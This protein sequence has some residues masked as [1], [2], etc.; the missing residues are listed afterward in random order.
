MPDTNG[1]PRN[2]VW[3]TMGGTENFFQAHVFDENGN[4]ERTLVQGPVYDN[5]LTPD[6]KR[7]DTFE[8]RISKNH[9]WFGMPDYGQAWV[10]GPVALDWSVGV[11]Q[12]GHH[13][14]NPTKDD[15]FPNAACRD[16][17]LGQCRDLTGA[18]V[19]DGEVRPAM[20]R[21]GGPDTL[22][23]LSPAPADAYLRFL[24]IGGNLEFRV[25]GGSWQAPH[26]QFG[27][28]NIDPSQV[29]ESYLTPIPAGARSIQ[30]RGQGTYGGKW[31]VQ[32]VA[33]WT[34]LGLHTAPTTGVV[35]PAA[36]GRIWDSRPGLGTI[37]GVGSG[38]GAFAAGSTY[39]LPVAGRAGVAVGAQ[40]AV[41]NLT[42]AGDRY[43]ICHCLAVRT[44]P[45]ER[46]EPE[47]HDR[48]A[49]RERCLHE[50]RRGRPCVP[51]RRRRH[52]SSHRRRQRHIRERSCSPPSVPHV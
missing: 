41:I 33:V 34:E 26:R 2:A 12:F 15:N 36:I 52:H 8:L 20:G 11:V 22:Q 3:I 25:D 48:C 47:L 40:S 24:G 6:A 23:L 14:Y 44:A 5:F 4:I 38:I 28:G 18:D 37:D 10:D 49:G 45:S 51:V 46:L 32:D 39:Q 9:L 19:H 7:R 1:R 17:A 16:V 42:A 50:D 31:R 35:D 13:S 21:D 29:F 30:F 43:R 27:N